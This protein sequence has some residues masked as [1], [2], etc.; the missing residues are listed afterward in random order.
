MSRRT[1]RSLL[2]AVGTTLMGALA[3]CSDRGPFASET[4]REYDDSALAALPGEIPHIPSTVPVQPT[5]AHLTSARERIRSL[6][7]GADVSRVPNA[8]VRQRLVRERK[9]AREAL[10]STADD[11]SRVETL[12]GLTHP[13]SEAMFVAAGLAAFDNSLTASDIETRR[14]RHHRDANAF[15]ADYAPAGPRDDPL[16]AFV[17]HARITD[18]GRTGARLIEPNTRYE[19]ENTVLHVAELA[20]HVEWGRAYAADAQQLHTDY[21]ATLDDPRDYEA[22]FASVATTL[23]DDVATH[24]TAPDQKTLAS[25]IDRDIADT[26]GETLLEDLARS[27]WSAAKTAVERH[28]AGHAVGAIG[29]AM[30]ALAA[31]R[32]FTAARDA[33]ADGA[34]GVPASVDPIAAERAAAV[35]GLRGLLDT[36]PALLARRLAHHVRNPIRNADEL[37]DEHTGVVAGRDIYATYAVASQ[38]AA[39]APPVVQ[40]VGDLLDG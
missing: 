19:Y 13:R 27:R 7:D 37:A 21:T 26:P 40:R 8:V 28:D 2:A 35:D 25:D 10:A 11:H 12:E 9:S 1:R 22:H 15:L 34:Y 4:S 33:V 31:D 39:A 38:F 6:L 30:R 16:G 24:A 36:R 3:G 32:A 29:P 5:D 14:E 17:E 20:Q 23:T 18:W